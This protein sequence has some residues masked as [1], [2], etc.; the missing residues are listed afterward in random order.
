MRHLI[1]QDFQSFVYQGVDV[2]FHY[3]LNLVFLIDLNERSSE[4]NDEKQLKNLRPIY[5]L[6]NIFHRQHLEEFDTK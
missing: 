6:K 2:E 3:H 4:K 5:S 1:Q